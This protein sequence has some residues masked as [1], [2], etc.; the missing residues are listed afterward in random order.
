MAK[1]ARQNKEKFEQAMEDR[2]AHRNE[3]NR[4]YQRML[5]RA[6]KPIANKLFV[7]AH[8]NSEALL[9]RNLEELLP[10][11][12]KGIYGSAEA[13]NIHKIQSAVTYACHYNSL[14]YHDRVMIDGVTYEG[15]IIPHWAITPVRELA[16]A[17]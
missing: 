4:K 3:R 17:A 2:R 5:S 9:A 12:A 11:L 15:Y 10:R 14:E 1:G 8:S 13:V 6:R 16:M 7:M